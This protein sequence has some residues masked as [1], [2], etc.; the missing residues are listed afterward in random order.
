MARKKQSKFNQVGALVGNRWRELALLVVLMGAGFGLLSLAGWDALDPN[1]FR[2]GEGEVRNPLGPLGASLGE[3]LYTLL[4][5]GAWALLV[6]M[7]LSFLS[8]AGRKVFRPVPW[9]MSL[10]LYGAGLGG[11]HLALGRDIHSAGGWVGETEAEVLREVAGTGGAAFFLGAVA[12]LA[13]T[14]LFHIDWSRVARWGMDR[15]EEVLPKVWGVAL[16]GG[17]WA[18]GQ[19]VAGG[20]KLGKL[21]VSSSKVAAGGLARG[22]VSAGQGGM[23]ALGLGGRMLRGVKG[24]G[25]RIWASLVRDEDE[26]WD[27]SYIGDELSQLDEEERASLVEEE[28]DPSSL[29]DDRT[30]A[31]S[32]ADLVEVEWFP[33]VV[34]GPG[35]EVLDLF[36]DLT[37]RPSQVEEDEAVEARWEPT[38]VS[39]PDALVPDERLSASEDDED[40]YDEDEL[41]DEDELSDEDDRYDG[42]ELPE[43]DDLSDE[44]DLPEGDERSDEDDRYDEDDL[45]DPL[46]APAPRSLSGMADPELPPEIHAAL[47]KVVVHHNRYLNARS[48][49][50][51][52]AVAEKDDFHL[53]PLSLLAEVPEQKVG[54]DAEALQ[55]L[56]A[57]LEEK[58]LTF[59]IGG[60]VVG[61]R[62]GPVVTIF[63]FKP[64]PGIKVS[65]IANLENDLA[66]A[67]MATRVR[68]VAPIPGRDVVGIEIPSA[69]RLTIYIREV[70]ASKVFRDNRMALPCVL[71]KDISGKP[72]VADLAKMPHLLVGGT[73]GSGKSVGVNGMLLSMLF[74][75][76]PDEL[77]M[78]LIDP[79][80]LEFSMYEGIPHLLHPVVTEPKVAAAALAWAV[81]EMDDR[82]RQLARV[83]VR[84]IVNYNNRIDQ[85]LENWD[86]K[87]ARRFAPPDFPKDEAPPRPARMP[88]IVIVI[89]ELADLMMVARNEVE[90]SVAR[91]AQKA[92]AAGMHLI[93]A[94]Q[95]PSAN[96]VTGLIKANLPSRISFQLRT[97]LDSRII[98]D[99]GGA[100]T[101]LGRGDMLYLSTSGALERC[102]GAFVDDPEVQRV[103][104]FLREQRAPQY[105]AEIRATD[106]DGPDVSEERDDN[107]YR[108]REVVL[109]AGKASTSMIQR[110][111]KIG[112]NKAA[113]IIDMMEAD[114][115]IGPAD[116]ARP[117]EV[118]MHPSQV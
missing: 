34:T 109:A 97:K 9:A 5:Y 99:D 40:R 77:R 22:A 82:Y 117:R 92:R 52:E 31:G 84:N 80:M 51:G 68:I 93:V 67:L 59:K 42:D 71:G 36:P 38:G 74:T 108:A 101:L 43:E 12:I 48:E 29:G 55:A 45:D 21:G 14:V 102:H 54:Y 86:P 91:I 23:Q 17:R 10:A 24:A 75:R 50:H 111:L 18:G 16:S 41:P 46:D 116:G 28:I 113:E 72:A 62:P 20:V 58:L 83:G 6:P 3:G 70:L 69:Q 96:V 105:I 114:G 60:E 57:V 78:L 15:L 112:Y 81:K 106:E 2:P 11:L 79:K 110:H 76:T 95:R 35:S 13:S 65:R 47:G 61:V 100:E 19:T 66:M 87:Q 85:L 73:T 27:D 63:E 104:D 33:T 53:P 1:Y 88:Y 44:D 39:H 26:G 94:T 64:A 4:G 90:E 8:L 7:G 56:G 103:T 89:D 98:L 118:L 37:P 25:H 32:P 30:M 107:Y 49:D 115:I